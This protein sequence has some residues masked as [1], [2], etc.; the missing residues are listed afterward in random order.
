MKVVKRYSNVSNLVIF[1]ATIFL[2]E[3]V[4]FCLKLLSRFYTEGLRGREQL[5]VAYRSGTALL[6]K[7]RHCFNKHNGKEQNSGNNAA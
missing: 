7:L 5:R 6:I 1:C 3:I 4:H 2:L